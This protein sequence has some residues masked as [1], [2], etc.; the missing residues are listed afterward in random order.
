[1]ETYDGYKAHGGVSAPDRYYFLD[2]Y[3]LE[4]NNP[5]KSEVEQNDFEAFFGLAD[6]FQT[7][8]EMYCWFN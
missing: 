8:K 1:M 5:A 3:G 6:E 4:K 2:L 7:D